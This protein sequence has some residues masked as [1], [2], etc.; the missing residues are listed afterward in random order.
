LRADAMEA[1]AASQEGGP[2]ESAATATTAAT[3]LEL[4]HGWEKAS[5]PEGSLVTDTHD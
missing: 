3:S 4:D 5:Y 2:P 1:V